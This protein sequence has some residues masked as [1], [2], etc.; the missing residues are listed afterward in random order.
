MTKRLPQKLIGDIQPH[1]ERCHCESRAALS[2]DE[3]ADDGTAARVLRL[4]FQLVSE[5]GARLVQVCF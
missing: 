1:H 2:A 3:P 4:L 5:S